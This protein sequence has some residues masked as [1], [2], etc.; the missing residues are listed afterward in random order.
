MENLAFFFSK[1]Y[2]ILYRISFNMHLLSRNKHEEPL[3]MC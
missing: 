2:F 1:T 3:Y